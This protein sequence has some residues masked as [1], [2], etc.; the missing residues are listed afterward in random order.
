M[1]LKVVVAC[2]I[3]ASC[4]SVPAFAETTPAVEAAPVA[5]VAATPGSPIVAQALP[6][7]GPGSALPSNTDIWVT[8]DKKLDSHDVK[9]GDPLTFKVARDVMLGN[10][11]VIPRGTPA[12]G[13]I[14]MRSGRGAFGKSAKLEFDIETITLSGH[15]IP[16]SGHFRLAGDGNTGATIG[17]VAAAGVIGGLFVKGRSAVAAEGSEWKVATKEPL[18]I[19]VGAAQ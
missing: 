8:L 6:Q 19:S 5:A 13:R 12:A 1:N 10:Y 11:I 9:V 7:V 17:A 18:P 2:G 4:L 3:A 16:V 15:A 14:S